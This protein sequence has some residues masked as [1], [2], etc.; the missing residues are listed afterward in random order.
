MNLILRLTILFL[1][2]TAVAPAREIVIS[3]DRT[4]MELRV[5]DD[6]SLTQRGYGIVGDT[7]PNPRRSDEMVHQFDFYPTFGDGYV[8]EPALQVTHADGDISTK[9]VVDDVE[10]VTDANDPNIVTTAIRL[11]DTVQDL[12]VTIYLRAF[13]REDVIQ[14]WTKIEN[15]EDGPVL[16]HRFASASPMNFSKSYWLTQFHG[17]HMNEGNMVEE[18]LTPGTKVLSSNLGARAHR[19]TSPM[20]LVSLND[21]ANEDSAYVIGSTFMWPGSFRF[22]FDIDSANNLHMIVGADR[23][24]SSYYLEKG[25]SLETPKSLWVFSTEGTGGVTRRFHDWGRKY[26]IRDPEKLRP[27]LLNNWEATNMNFDEER[28]VSLFDSAQGTGVDIFLLDDGWFGNKYQRDDDTRGLGDWEVAKSKLPRGLGYL[29]EEAKKRD[30]GFGIWLEPEM[31]SPKSELYE[32]HPDWALSSPGRKP[33]LG[34][35]QQVLDLTNPM[36]RDFVWSIFKNTLGPNPIQYVKWDA[37]CCIYQPSSSYLPKAAQ[38]NLDFDYN[39]S[40][41]Q[42]MS[43]FAKEF[44]ETMAMLCSGGSGRVDYASLAN[45]DSFWVSDN[46]DPLKR[47]FIQWGFSHFF[48]SLTQSAHVTH[49]GDRPVKFSLDV[50]MS[51]ALGFDI[52][53]SKVSTEDMDLIKSDIELYKK[54]IRPITANGDYHRLKSPYHHAQSA[55]LFAA[56]DKSQ[57]VLFTYQTRDD[58]KDQTVRL[59]GLNPEKSYTIQEVA[60]RDGVKSALSA[61]GS[62]VSGKDLMEKGLLIPTEKKCGSAVILL[63][64]VEKAIEKEAAAR[65]RAS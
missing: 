44:P 1:A 47:V 34:R 58:S 48:P 10:T 9:L 43:K 30:L 57:A 63:K 35:N 29:C 32:K 64:G 13:Q 7:F 54:E 23:V 31:I 18:R 24:G 12:S 14:I 51:G 40:L 20:F 26:A 41:L 25:Q 56:K 15:K 61:D 21:P 36:V 62:T 49:M 16:L 65:E 38:G 46:T 11:K 6:G 28:L 5:E 33:I 2:T 8:L 27:V 42:I 4:K 45:F 60:L 52:D 59:K 53:F 17:N 37:N 39:S 50:A 3:T 55:V 19:M 22:S